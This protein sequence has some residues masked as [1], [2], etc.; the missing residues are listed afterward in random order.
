MTMFKVDKN[1]NQI[2]SKLE[3]LSLFDTDGLDS[4]YSG[5]LGRAVANT[6]LFDF[7]NNE[8]YFNRA[9][10]IFQFSIDRLGDSNGLRFSTALSNGLSGLGMVGLVLERKSDGE[11]SSNFEL[12]IQ[13]VA[14][15]I[16]VK[17]LIEIKQGDLDPLH[18]SIGGL[19]FLA[20]YA[21][22]NKAKGKQYLIELLETLYLELNQNKFGYYLLNKRYM[23]GG[24]A[25]I[26]IGLG[27][28]L[29]GIILSLIEVY[30]VLNDEM[31]RELIIKLTKFLESTYTSYHQSEEKFLFPRSVSISGEPISQEVRRN[32]NIGWCSSDLIIGYT[33]LKA[34]K[35]LDD[36]DLEAWG[37]KVLF[38]FLCYDTSKLPIPDAIFC[39]GYSGVSWVLRKCFYA[40]GQ[41]KFLEKSDFWLEKALFCPKTYKKEGLLEGDLGIYTTILGSMMNHQGC[42][43]E[44][45]LL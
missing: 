41:K 28:G 34:G 13:W 10:E 9:L 18:S 24:T 44:I 23:K 33:F 30:A 25:N 20:K 37:N 6:V 32:H 7:S 22:R 43:D 3:R 29:C 35:V 26:E 19:Y 45:F 39:H 27:H 4:L 17:A 16:F 40:T 5:N 12:L 11:V 8:L 42:W 36:Q 1:I 21:Q 15:N 31:S 2:V 38:G 14:K